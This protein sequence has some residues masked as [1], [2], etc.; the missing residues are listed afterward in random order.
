MYS[1]PSGSNLG[2]AR[3]SFNIDAMGAF[4]EETYK[5]WVPLPGVKAFTVSTTDRVIIGAEEFSADAATSLYSMIVGANY[6]LTAS[7]VEMGCQLL[8]ANNNVP[9]RKVCRHTVDTYG[10]LPLR[11]AFEAVVGTF[12]FVNFYRSLSSDTTS[13]GKLV[14]DAPAYRKFT[15]DGVGYIVSAAAVTT[16]SVQDGPRWITLAI[17]PQG[18]VYEVLENVRTIVILVTVAIIIVCTMIAVISVNFILGPVG[19]IAELM[20]AAAYLLDTNNN[21]NTTNTGGSGSTASYEAKGRRLLANDA[22]RSL[23][24]LA[25]VRAI[26]SAYWAMSDELQILKAY[27]PEH[28]REEIMAA[29]LRASN[30]NTSSFDSQPPKFGSLKSPTSEELSELELLARNNPFNIDRSEDVSDPSL[31]TS[32]ERDEVEEFNLVS[33]SHTNP[34]SNPLTVSDVLTSNLTTPTHRGNIQAAGDDTA[35]TVVQQS[36]D[37]QT[38]GTFNSTA[39]SE[40]MHR[41]QDPPPQIHRLNR[42]GSAESVRKASGEGATTRIQHQRHNDN[43]DEG[44]PFQPVFFADSCLIDRFITVVHLNII[45]FHTYARRRHP[46]TISTDY[47]EFITYLNAEAKRFGG[48][49]EHFSGDKFWVSFN[50]TSKCVKHQVAACYFAY[51]LSTIV[52]EASIRYRRAYPTAEPVDG[53]VPV[54]PTIDSR[55]A[56]C[57][58]GMNCGISTGHAY[59]GPVGNSAIKRHTIISNAMSE[60]AAL[61]RVSLHFMGNSNMFVSRDILPHIE[62]Y[63]QYMLLDVITLPGP[64][65]RRSPMACLMGVMLGPNADASVVQRWLTKDPQ[66]PTNGDGLSGYSLPLVPAGKPSDPALPVSVPITTTPQKLPTSSRYAASNA[67]FMAVMNSKPELAQ[68]HLAEA[69]SQLRANRPGFE[70]EFEFE[71][72]TTML[73]FVIDL[74]KAFITTKTDCRYYISNLGELFSLEGQK[75]LKGIHERSSKQRRQARSKTVIKDGEQG[76]NKDTN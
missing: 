6:S 12:T 68:T 4:P 72:K 26:Q 29:K 11:A 36:S 20:T 44:E 64:N 14:L 52:N 69:E 56:L 3:L 39:T 67:A 62:G 61:E 17:V 70:T 8:E 31:S 25:E 37:V 30:K 27:I 48:V 9:R 73:G 13:A 53:S 32:R 50:A 45:S 22:G 24:R 47:A 18:E 66:P 38:H 71:A 76:T 63:I 16:N 15:V 1:S 74:V 60:A 43:R 5:S 57:V 59:V 23:S 65:G 41:G 46:T 40:Q 75:G 19:D 35:I 10:N 33:P 54:V 58:G 7:E 21:N 42:K 55:L 49:L 34:N 2:K 51:H 28:L